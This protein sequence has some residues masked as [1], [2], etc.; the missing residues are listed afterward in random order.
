[1]NGVTL[2]KVVASYGDDAQA[3]S[4]VAAIALIAALSV[5][6][7]LLRVRTRRMQLADAALRTRRR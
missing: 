4:T 2:S 7:L 3:S 6:F 1:M 5:C